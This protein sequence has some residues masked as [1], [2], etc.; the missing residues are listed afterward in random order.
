MP[1][2]MGARACGCSRASARVGVWVPGCA[3]AR[4]RRCAAVRARERKRAR[5]SAQASLRSLF[6]LGGSVVTLAEVAGA[7]WGG[8]LRRRRAAAA[9][10]SAGPQE[11]ER[12]G[13]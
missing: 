12:E 5:T 6:A 3:G 2:C 11:G 8:A 13:A 7:S 9:R 10:L 1:G 4:A